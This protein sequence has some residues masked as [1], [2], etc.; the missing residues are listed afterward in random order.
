MILNQVFD[1]KTF[2]KLEF[3]VNYSDRFWVLLTTKAAPKFFDLS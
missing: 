1:P 2:R 3:L